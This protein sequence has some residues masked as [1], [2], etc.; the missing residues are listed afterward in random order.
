MGPSDYPT[1]RFTEGARVGFLRMAGEERTDVATETGDDWPG[2]PC[3][4][5]HPRVIGKAAT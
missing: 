2:R 5:V 1:A 3:A 4:S